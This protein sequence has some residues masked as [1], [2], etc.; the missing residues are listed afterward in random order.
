VETDVVVVVSVKF[1]EIVL[2]V[3]VIVPETNEREVIVE[4][5]V[6]GTV[7]VPEHGEVTVVVTVGPD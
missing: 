3:I 4:T 6:V 2:V 1:P 7:V 5:I